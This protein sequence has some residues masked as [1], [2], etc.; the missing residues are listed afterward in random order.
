MA[1]LKTLKIE[2]LI[3]SCSYVGSAYTTGGHPTG[4]TN[5]FAYL[6]EDCDL[7][8]FLTAKFGTEP[9]ARKIACSKF[10]T[11]ETEEVFQDPTFVRGLRSYP[12]SDEASFE[13][14]KAYCYPKPAVTT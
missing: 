10:W 1:E 8:I 6:E 11:D 9:D 13:A 12:A 2:H 5:V 3:S 7:S 14:F 4:V